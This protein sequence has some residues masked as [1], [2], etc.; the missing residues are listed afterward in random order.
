M[1]PESNA[2]DIYY[3]DFDVD[4]DPLE[5]F[6]D[7]EEDE[8]QGQVGPHTDAQ[9]RVVYQP[10]PDNR[11]PEERIADLFESLAPRRRV[12]LGI[13]MYLQEQHRTDAL[14]EEV[15][16]LQTYDKSVYNGY[17]FS[18]LLEE[19][20][21]IVK[22]EE[23][24]S[25]F[26]ETLEQAPDIVEIDGVRFYKP[27]DG[28]Q[29]FWLITD[30]GRAYLEQDNPFGRLSELLDAEQQ[31]L[32]IYKRLLEACN[33]D[34]GALRATLEGLV[35]GDPLVQNPPR[36]CS[37]FTKRLED[38]GAIVWEGSWKTTDAGRRGLEELFPVDV[39]GVAVEGGK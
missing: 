34:K 11:T 24:G 38:A 14:Q 6:E 2:D 31:Y 32:P 35:N 1:N 39:E 26:D 9:S 4:Y 36:Y 27:T 13:L 19:A 10:K 37:F 17:D 7:V 22:V 20:G 21:A 18:V 30:A 23:D 16:R 25:P 29:V 28:K 33:T 8:S 15:E 3:E 12:L 5:D